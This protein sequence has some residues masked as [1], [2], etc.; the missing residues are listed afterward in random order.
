M[1]REVLDFAKLRGIAGAATPGPWQW[2][3]NTKMYDVYLATVDRGRRFV[4]DFVRWGMSGA[5]PR[6]QVRINGDEG[7]GI[8]RSVGELG[9]DESSLGPLFEASHRRQFTG[10]GHPDAAYIAAFSPDVALTLIDR[11]EK[12]ER[13][14]DAAIKAR[15]ELDGWVRAC[16]KAV[17]DRTAETLASHIDALIEANPDDW[18]ITGDDVRAGAWRPK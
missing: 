15:D 2:F 9:K 11:I 6:F 5:Q 17:E 1:T 7:S 8:M 10:I 13:E 4:M 18:S 14:R 16:T 12:A 3:G